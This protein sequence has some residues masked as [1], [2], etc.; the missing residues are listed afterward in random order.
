MIS[1]IFSFL[2]LSPKVLL[3]VLAV[4][5]AIGLLVYVYRK[6]RIEKEPGSL[7]V[8]LVL[9]GMLS[10]FLAVVAESVGA[11]ALAFFLPGGEENPAYGFWMFFVV[12]GLSEEGFKYLV[13]R[14]RTWKSPHFNCSFDGVVYAVFVSLGFALWENIGYVLMYG[15]GAALTRA[16]TAVP[17][18]ASFGVFMGA[19]YAAAKRCENYGEHGKS[20]FWS[21]LS[22]LLPAAIHGCYD[23]I[24]VIES[25]GNSTL[26]I[27]FV[28][29]VF[30]AAFLMIKKL[31]DRDSFI[32]PDGW[33]R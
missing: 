29:A 7:L 1:L 10:T 16:V 4:V 28:L 31:S 25:G 24:A 5:P 18:H 6:D 3:I 26:F 12:V 32:A 2:F 19:C 9:W 33:Y 23:Y 30:A 17:G 11:S 20:R 21:V 22:V 8:S 27:V 14:W 15:I 13:L